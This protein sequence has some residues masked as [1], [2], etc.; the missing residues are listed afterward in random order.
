MGAGEGGMRCTQGSPLGQFLRCGDHRMGGRVT[1]DGPRAPA[2]VSG[3]S[4]RGCARGVPAP[5][6]DGP[7]PVGCSLRAWRCIQAQARGSLAGGSPRAFNGQHRTS[8]TAA[9]VAA[10]HPLGWPPA[11]A[12]T[13]G[14]ADRSARRDSKRHHGTHGLPGRTRSR[15][16][17]QALTASTVLASWAVSR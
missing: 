9:P 10:R 3:V 16:P 8:G 7:L 1:M 11:D 17:G 2:A 12:G 13:T 15:A 4:G 5:R 14:G 6:L